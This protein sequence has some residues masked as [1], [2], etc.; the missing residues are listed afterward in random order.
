MFKKIQNKTSRNIN[1]VHI[2]G[3]NIENLGLY[4][5][6]EFE[7][8]YV[9]EKEV[10]EKYIAGR[11]MPY[12][13]VIRK[14]PIQFSVTF[15]MKETTDF[16]ARIDYIRNFLESKK[17]KLITFNNENKGFKIYWFTIRDITRK[18]GAS[19]ITIT[20][21]CYPDIYDR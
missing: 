1:V 21:Q 3:I 10:E 6:K 2:D 5:D 20:F 14:L 7:L 17:E 18:T 12:H 4:L 9:Q 11:D 16:Y 15:N 19:T 8:S 13:K